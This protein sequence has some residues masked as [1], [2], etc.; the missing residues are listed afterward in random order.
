MNNSNLVSTCNFRGKDYLI[1]LYSDKN[2]SSNIEIKVTEKKTLEEWR[3]SY[4]ASYVET[5]TQKTGNYKRFDTFISMLKSGLLETSNCVTLDLLTLEDLEMLRNRVSH[6][7][8]FGATHA[9]I[10]GSQAQS[11]NRRYLIVTYTVEFDR[12]HYPLALEYCGLP[13]PRIL[14]E[15][16]HRLEK[17]VHDLEHQLHGGNWKDITAQIDMLQKRVVDVTTENL[18]LKEKLHGLNKSSYLNKSKESQRDGNI[19][20][21]SIYALENKL[22]SKS[23]GIQKLKEENSLLSI[24]L[25]EALKSEKMLR[26]QLKRYQNEHQFANIRYKEFKKGLSPTP[27]RNRSLEN[28]VEKP[29]SRCFLSDRKINSGRSSFNSGRSSSED[30]AYFRNKKMKSK[31]CSSPT[32]RAVSPSP[33]DLS[34]NSDISRCCCKK[35]MTLNLKFDKT[36]PRNNK[37]I[38]GI[39]KTALMKRIRSLEILIGG[40]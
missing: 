38:K 34:H 1:N 19:L 30:S 36:I 21:Q 5:L 13:D 12:I 33:S 25:D 10:V 29:F 2:C 31:G 39:S 32:P 24:K 6:S 9:H 23:E 16:I 7:R 37:Q 27:N 26:N 3:G 8:G 35:C 28:L 14:Q 4:D 22:K 17:Q 40:M 18:F 20:V 15:T 11:N